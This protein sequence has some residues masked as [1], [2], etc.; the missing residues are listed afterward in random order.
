[1]IAVET[2]LTLVFLAIALALVARR[3]G[4]PYPIALVLGGLA[5]GFIPELPRLRFDPDLVFFIF[6][7]PLLYHAAVFTSWRDFRERIGTISL[8]GIGLVVATTV[9][10]AVVVHYFIPELPW[11]AAF[12]LG[13]I[14][15]PPDA[16]CAT[17]AMKNVRV[18]RALTTVLEGESL[19]NDAAGLVIYKYAIAAVLSGAFSA[20]DVAADFVYVGAG[21]VVI[22]VAAGYLFARLHRALDDPLIEVAVGLAIPF[23]V[24]LLADRLGTSGVVA[25]VTAGLL[26]GWYMP[27][28]ATAQAR[29]RGYAAW[30]VMIF[31][32]NGLVFILIGSELD[33]M[34]LNIPNF[35]IWHLLRYAALVAGAVVLARFAWIFAASYGRHFILRLFGPRAAPDWRLLFILSWSG[36]RGVVS[37]AAALAI[38]L[39]TLAGEPFPGRALIGFLTFAVIFVTLVIQGMTIGPIARLLKLEVGD[40]EAQEERLARVS[41]GRAA[42][43]EIDRLAREGKISAEILGALRVEI[44]AQVEDME[45]PD[46]LEAEAALKKAV[47]AATVRG[48]VVRAMIAAQRRELLVLR[49]KKQIGDAVFHRVEHELD[50]QEAVLV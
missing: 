11:A 9:S 23:A 45:R 16:V 18:P 6:L 25:V 3:A 17:A 20:V 49:R 2:L 4:M 46:G 38:P 22:G 28:I 48:E 14:V 33:D 37:L 10:V 29:I 19:I 21:G 47:P 34:V 27:E 40:E 8:L 44:A 50:L 39:V 43:G 30:D 5:L 7:P 41:I 15:S 35:G 42:M 26:R 1:M 12:L 36:M 32:L 24:Y 31:I 13:A